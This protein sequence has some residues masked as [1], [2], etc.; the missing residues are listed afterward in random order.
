[1]GRELIGKEYPS[2][3]SL[4][5]LRC[6]FVAPLLG[7]AIL[8]NMCSD[9]QCSSI[10]IYYILPMTD[11]FTVPSISFL[12]FFR[13]ARRSSALPFSKTAILKF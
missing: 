1:M 6:A 12:K 3:P 4:M 7:L 5:V 11:I 13:N 2:K 9:F 10:H 8:S